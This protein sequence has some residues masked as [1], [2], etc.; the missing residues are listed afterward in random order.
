MQ[1]RFITL[2]DPGRRVMRFEDLAR[3]GDPTRST[4][5]WWLTIDAQLFY[6]V[7]SRFPTS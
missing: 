5:K 4:S 7:L 2:K 6:S 1:S 3:G